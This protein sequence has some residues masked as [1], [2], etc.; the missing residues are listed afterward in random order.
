MLSTRHLCYR[1]YSV[2][3]VPNVQQTLLQLLNIVNLWLKTVVLRFWVPRGGLGQRTMFIYRLIGK[4][5]VDFLLVFIELFE[6]CYCWGATSEYRL[7][8]GDFAPTGSAWHKISGRRGG[9]EKNSAKWSFVS[10][11]NLD[12]S[13]FR[14]VIV[15]AFDRRTDTQ[16]DKRTDRQTDSWILLGLWP[17]FGWYVLAKSQWDSHY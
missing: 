13:F 15:H 9:S 16:T 2:K 12:K 6:S 8:I 3:A 14:F 17:V 7:K 11:K 1:L 4:R 10:Y 5:V